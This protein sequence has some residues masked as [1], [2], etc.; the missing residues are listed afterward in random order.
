MAQ[1]ERALLSP[2]NGAVG[3][4]AGVGIV[5]EAEGR[6][7][8]QP[9]FFSQLL[10]ADGSANPAAG[11]PAQELAMAGLAPVVAN[12]PASPLDLVAVDPASPGKAG[13]PLAVAALA[14]GIEP[15]ADEGEPVDPEETA[16]GTG[17]G[18]GDAETA[19]GAALTEAPWPG[20]PL[21]LAARAALREA[22]SANVESSSSSGTAAAGGSVDS[23]RLR[24]MLR[25]ATAPG[26]W[27]EGGRGPARLTGEPAAGTLNDTSLPSVARSAVA[28]VGGLPLSGTG[29]LARIASGVT[30]ATPLERSAA[31]LTDFPPRSG[32]TGVASLETP[33]LAAVA[34]VERATA[35][36]ATATA[37]D[38]P[39]ATGQY[40]IA[41]GRQAGQAARSRPAQG[42]PLL[43]E[44]FAET[45]S[46]LL[47]GV[48]AVS[49]DSAAPVGAAWP[50]TA[51]AA[52]GTVG[53]ADE[54]PVGGGPD[55]TALATAAQVYRRSADAV[56]VPVTARPEEVLPDVTAIGAG[57]SPLAANGGTPIP[58]T[59]PS[60][61]P[62]RPDAGTAPILPPTAPDV[63]D[64][65]QKNWGRALGHQLN[66]M[67]SNRVQEAEIR[68]NP[69][70]LGPLEVRVSL[71]HNQTS[72]T[73][74]SHEAAVRE[75]IE[76]ALPR[77]R[78][79]LDGQGINLNQAQVSD[80]SLARQQSGS[81]EQAFQGSRSGGWLLAA[82]A[83]T[84]DEEAG[85]PV[86]S[87]GLLG[88][89]DDYV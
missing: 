76:S 11:V 13:E 79:M 27:M 28:E 4:A 16:T 31:R 21:C 6:T 64:L 32:S 58:A 75:A 66:W 7:A 26:R 46:G 20:L 23:A 89:V 68:V 45:E 8:A 47:A 19:A 52:V 77:L 14:P 60:A 25:A 1:L 69:P 82:N 10:Q 41:S 62:A 22:G 29:S 65:Q 44:A 42:Y 72:V 51:A 55:L 40:E 78:E 54:P 34:G 67:V 59:A 70:D 17:I 18:D 24:L 50:A 39:V 49:V 73:F 9:P 53:D 80:Q 74:F 37:G 71:H 12:P 63:L 15:A 3:I 83:E 86:R 36:A 43:A 88:M 85:R 57:E 81:G 35:P 48:R 30:G 84:R 61:A 2:A 56:V 5:V 33:G 87:R 38:E